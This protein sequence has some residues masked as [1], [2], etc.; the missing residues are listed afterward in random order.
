VIEE[1]KRDETLR[2]IPVIVLT[3]SADP[4]DINACNQ[5]GANRYV[6]R[7]VALNALMKAIQRLKDFRF[8]V[9]IWPKGGQVL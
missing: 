1:L 8:E 7:P 2:R 3:M 4:R 9:V 6:Q 5:A